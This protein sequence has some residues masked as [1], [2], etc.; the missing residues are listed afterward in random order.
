[1]LYMHAA[2]QKLSHYQNGKHTTNNGTNQQRK[3]YTVIART[4]AQ[5]HRSHPLIFQKNTEQQV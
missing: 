1:M 4:A 3:F 5:T 2:L